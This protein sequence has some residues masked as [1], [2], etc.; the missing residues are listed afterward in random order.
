MKNRGR[1]ETRK[2]TR[3]RRSQ[4]NRRILGFLTAVM[5]VAITGVV[6]ASITNRTEAVVS[7]ETTAD[8]GNFVGA[9][10]ITWR[11]CAGDSVWRICERLHT[12]YQV[13]HDSVGEMFDRTLRINGID[14]EGVI[15]V[16]S[17]LRVQFYI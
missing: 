7:A 12:E 6:A 4:R 15:R 8:T 5:L 3:N 14:P 9:T 17:S 2:E 13:E 16:G 11:V 1:K 10:T